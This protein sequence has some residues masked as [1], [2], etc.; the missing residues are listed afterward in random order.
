MRREP[1]Y[2]N[3]VGEC[4]RKGIY[5]SDIAAA[6][7]CT[8]RALNNKMNGRSH[9]TWPEVYTIHRCFFPNVTKDYLMQT[10]GAM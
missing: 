7:G 4:A 10:T 8:T 9:F 5:M 6:I 2:P 1:H 3:L